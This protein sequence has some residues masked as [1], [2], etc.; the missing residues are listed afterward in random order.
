M[1]TPNQP[2]IL[3]IIESSKQALQDASSSSPTCPLIALGEV[4]AEDEVG[5][6]QALLPQ[7]RRHLRAELQ[8]S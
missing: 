8:I 2:K 1:N 4:Y 5:R 6:L 7:R 3:S